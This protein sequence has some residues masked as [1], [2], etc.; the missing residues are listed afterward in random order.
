MI[1][2]LFSLIILAL[3]FGVIWWILDRMPIPAPFNMIVRVVLGLILIIIL[4]GY[5]GIGPGVGVVGS[6]GVISIK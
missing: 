1:S 3:V 4:L 6:H 2:L 5:V